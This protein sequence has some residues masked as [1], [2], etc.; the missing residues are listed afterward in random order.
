M[1]GFYIRFKNTKI[2]TTHTS[3]LSPQPHSVQYHATL[4]R[5]MSRRI[6]RSTVVSSEV[7]SFKTP[8]ASALCV[9]HWVRLLQ[10]V[11]VLAGGSQIQNRYHCVFDYT[12]I[13]SPA[14]WRRQRVSK[15][16]NIDPRGRA[17]RQA[18]R[19]VSSF[20]V[21]FCLLLIMNLVAA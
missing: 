14:P 6:K 8:R 19:L 1:Q 11:Y 12:W 15:T 2:P 5:H 10:C 21:P 4:M 3:A 7:Y 13:C 9:E 17:G 20:C 16:Q 18:T